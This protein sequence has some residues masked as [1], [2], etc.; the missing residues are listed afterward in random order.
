M[1]EK[2]STTTA[3]K[4]AKKKTV[5]K[6]APKKVAA[7]KAAPKKATPKAAAPKAVAPKVQGKT[8]VSPLERWKMIAEAAYYRAEKRGFL[9]GNPMQD[10]T[11]A[12]QEID[13]KYTIDYGRL[14]AR[15]DPGAVVEQLKAAL[16]GQ[17]FSKIDVHAV[18]DTQLKNVEAVTAANQ[19]VIDSAVALVN[20][21]N[22]ILDEA[23][24]MVTS[25]A[26]D[27]AKTKSPRDAVEKQSELIRV[28]MGKALEEMRATVETV[29]RS[30]AEAAGL[31][32]T[33]FADSLKEFK[34]VVA[35]IKKKK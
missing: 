12:E 21:Q 27:V 1:S 33:R 10:W 6:A 2:T 4:S 29:T 35:E 24:G 25:A 11:D 8:A 23:V 31:M 28:G 16:T 15:L 18:I 32:K 14:L 26:K 3:A 34:S 7:K 22:E 17:Q 13:A 9:G 20:R 5:G 30:N 19:D